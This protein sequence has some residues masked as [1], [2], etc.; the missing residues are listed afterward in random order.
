MCEGSLTPL[1]DPVVNRFR[2][3]RGDAIVFWRRVGK[4][5]GEIVHIETTIILIVSYKCIFLAT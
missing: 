2:E 4:G 1:T 3:E 5:I